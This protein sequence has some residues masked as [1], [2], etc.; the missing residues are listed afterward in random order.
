MFWRNNFLSVSLIEPVASHDE[1]GGAEHST[2]D[3]D[4]FFEQTLSFYRIESWILLHYDPMTLSSNLNQFNFD[5]KVKLNARQKYV[6][7][8]TLNFMNFMKSVKIKFS[9]MIILTNFKLW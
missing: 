8:S 7:T 6:Y 9:F 2:N 4:V 3:R 1:P 5:L